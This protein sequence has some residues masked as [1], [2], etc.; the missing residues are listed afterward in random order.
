MKKM[1]IIIIIF[2][3]CISYKVSVKAYEEYKIGD[4]LTYNDINFYVIYDSSSDDEYVTLL[5]EVPLTFEETVKYGSTS[6]YKSVDGYGGVIFDT[7]YESNCCGYYNSSNHQSTVKEIV[8]AWVADKIG[9]DNL[10]EDYTGYRARLISLED[11]YKLGYEKPSTCNNLSI[12]SNVPKW[13]Y[14]SDYGYWTMNAYCSG[15]WI[16]YAVRQTGGVIGNGYGVDNVLRPVITL[17]KD[18]LN[19]YIEIIMGHNQSHN[20]ASGNNTNST[21]IDKILDN[22]KVNEINN[23]NTNNIDII[24]DKEDKSFVSEIVKVSNTLLNNKINS[25]LIGLLLIGISITMIVML[26]KKK[27]YKIGE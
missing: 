18:A 12:N 26:L 17:K 11:L 20:N 6:T 13:L 27:K 19:E 10:V 16:V 21:I 24:D 4:T 22:D 7:K 5:K 14:S 9:L 1:F 3:I 15:M 2:L 25:I 23:D 8:D